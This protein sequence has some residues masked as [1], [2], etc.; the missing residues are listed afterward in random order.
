MA[1]WPNLILWYDLYQW[2]KKHQRVLL[3]VSTDEIAGCWN[4]STR[5]VG[6]HI[7]TRNILYRNGSKCMKLTQH[8]TE[9]PGQV[10]I[11]IISWPLPIL[12]GQHLV[13]LSGR[14][15]SDTAQVLPNGMLNSIKQKTCQIHTIS[16]CARLCISDVMFNSPFSTASEIPSEYTPAGMEIGSCLFAHGE[17]KMPWASWSPYT[18]RPGGPRDVYTKFGEDRS[19]CCKDMSWTILYPRD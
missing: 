16:R 10:H 15:V 4:W 7:V 5:W 12:T 9:L 19:Y 11:Y 8:Y 1:T 6:E 14:N 3:K 2:K 13:T 17:L 18:A